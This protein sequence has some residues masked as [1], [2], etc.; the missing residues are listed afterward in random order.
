MGKR[1]IVEEI[2]NNS[3]SGAAGCLVVLVMFLIAC[4]FFCR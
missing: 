4:Y 3:G 2:D 1:Y